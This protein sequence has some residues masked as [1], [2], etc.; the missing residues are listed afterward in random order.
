LQKKRAWKRVNRE[1]K[2]ELFEDEL[3]K[4]GEGKHN[5]RG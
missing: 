5:L 2:L 3:K 1:E 4:L